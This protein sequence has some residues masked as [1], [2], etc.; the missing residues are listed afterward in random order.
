MFTAYPSFELV[1]ITG[2]TGKLSVVIFVSY[3]SASWNSVPAFHH[4]RTKRLEN[5]VLDFYYVRTSLLGHIWIEEKLARWISIF[6]YRILEPPINRG[7]L[8]CSSVEVGD[9]AFTGVGGFQHRHSA[10]NTCFRFQHRL[11]RCR[12]RQTWYNFWKPPETIIFMLCALLISPIW[13]AMHGTRPHLKIF[14][15]GDIVLCGP[16]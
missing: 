10:R 6:S 12:S 9:V 4:V 16:L 2:Y 11:D 7:P 1:T 15:T 8:F 14:P 13:W 3:G 5:F